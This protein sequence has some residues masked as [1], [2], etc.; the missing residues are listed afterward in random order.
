MV[1]KL[2]RLARNIR[3]YAEVRGDLERAGVELVSVT[4][5]LE[6]TASGK[7]VEGMLAV[8][9][10]W[11]SNN[12]SAEI[13][14]G[15][16]QK[17]REGGWP[18]AAPIGYRNVR[19]EPG[20]G[21][22][23]GRATI[24]PDEQ[25]PL[26]RE[27]F[28]L[29]ATGG[30]PLTA[31]A[32]ELHDRGLRN[33]RGGRVSRSR[34]HSILRSP[35]YVGKVLWKG[36]TYEGT[37]EATIVPAD[38][39]QHVQELLD[40]H[41][42]AKE[43][44]RRHT[45]FLKGLLRCGRCGN[46]LIYNVVKGRNKRDFPYFACASHFNARNKCGEPYVP[47]G[48]LET[49]VENLYRGIKL[50]PRF[51]ER[52]EGILEDEVARSERHRAQASRFASRR[53]ERLAGERERLLDLYL[54]GDIDREAFRA[55]KDKIDAETRDLEAR[56]ADQ[57]AQLAQARELVALALKLARN[58]YRSYRKASPETKKLWN[59]AFFDRITVKGREVVDVRY[60]EPFRAI[61]GIGEGRVSDNDLLV[62][63]GGFEPPTHGLKAHCSDQAELTPLGSRA[64]AACEP[65]SPFD[66]SPA[67]SL[68]P[69]H[70]RGYRSP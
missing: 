5:G 45:H 29:Y 70:P 51:E 40:A 30:W 31:L 32:E 10:E 63:R 17:L 55:R 54:G 41:G 35:A 68:L 39:F 4:E 56:M 25:A 49:A 24:V 26:V 64:R 44:Q 52:L 60:A 66:C 21:Q 33:R 20:P 16:E 13:R 53:L 61:F 28:E 27:A 8:V 59:Q 19:E 65:R 11:Y 46:R 50:P 7:M 2:D 23:R 15:Q 6:A 14:K 62:G 18:T 38:V 43:R 22:R 58:C 34:L 3:D 12:L 67:G 57:T 48:V 9:A 47:A 36:A 69:H 42:R 37:H 1:H